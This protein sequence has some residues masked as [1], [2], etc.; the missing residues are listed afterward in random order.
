PQREDDAA[1]EQLAPVFEPD[2][3]KTVAL[4]KGDRALR[5][6][7]V[8]PELARLD[9]CPLGQLGARY[10][11][12][13]AEIVLDPPRGCGLPPQCDRAEYALAD[14]PPGRP[15]T[16][17]RSWDAAGAGGPRRSPA[18]SAR[19]PLCGFARTLS[20]PSSTTGSRGWAIRPSASHAFARRSSMSTQSCSS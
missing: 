10:S 6:P 9:L 12:R 4:R 3:V 1:R 19:S 16:P 5:H 11:G 20:P 18:A 8:H 14:T 7:D 17:T 2:E 13:K 15:P